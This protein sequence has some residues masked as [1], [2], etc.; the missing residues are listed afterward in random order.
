MTADNSKLFQKAIETSDLSLLATIPKSDLHN[1]APLGSRLQDFEKAIAQKLPLPPLKM[2]SIAEMDSYIFGN[3]RQHIVSL[4][5]LETSLRLAFR[6]AKTD[7]I[8]T[9]EMSID[10][11]FVALFADKEKGL[12]QLLQQIHKEEAPEIQY[13]PEIG[14][15]RD[16][17]VK[18]I[19]PLI[20]PCIESGYFKSI[21]LYGNELIKDARHYIPIYK[22]ARDKGLKLKS[23]AGEFGD[24]ESVR[25]TVDTLEL[26]EVQ[27]G[28]A[29]AQ[30]ADVMKWLR[31]NNIRL[32]ICPSSNVALSRVET[33]ALH[34][35]RTLADNGIIITI[36]TD[37]ILLFNQSVSEEFLNLYHAG[38]FSA[39]DLNIIRE[40]GL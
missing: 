24:A 7:G 10:C 28:I 4:N 32:N 8:Q 25:Y 27:H 18:D 2:E 35:A 16:A 11:F 37:D 17:D 19:E 30:S 6:Q 33:M 1:H 12:I 3:L 9:L 38:L 29:A 34:P 20:F 15:S 14:L 39:A 26:D 36:N 40:K 31:N 21:D 5:G 22:L 13:N 23:H